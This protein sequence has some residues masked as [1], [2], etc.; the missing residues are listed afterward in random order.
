MSS[1]KM[2]YPENVLPHS[3]FG[4]R[5]ILIQNTG[6]RLPETPKNVFR[7]SGKWFPDIFG[8]FVY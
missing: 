4:I 1:P 7:K 8:V 3:F 6:K 5:V 2:S